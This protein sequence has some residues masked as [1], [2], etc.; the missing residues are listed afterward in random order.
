MRIGLIAALVLL[1]AG[2]VGAQGFTMRFSGDII[3]PRGTV[4]DGTAITMN[5]RV[6][7]DGILNGDAMSRNG[8]VAVSGTV[9]GSVRAFNGD[10]ILVSTAVV[11]GDIWSANG[12]VDRQP[13]AQIRGQVRTSRTPPG[14]PS[15]PPMTSRRGDGRW[16]WWWPG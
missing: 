4:L 11:D 1:A 2:P 10:I 15:G 9:H 14:S 8:D 13:G 3:V 5:G 6:Q 7:V 12:R 16:S